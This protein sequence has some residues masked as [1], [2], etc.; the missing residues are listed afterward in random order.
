VAAGW[1]VIADTL[2]LL[3]CAAAG[4]GSVLTPERSLSLKAALGEGKPLWVVRAAMGCG[5]A[6]F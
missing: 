2:L 5:D 4:T 6:H 1:R 3:P